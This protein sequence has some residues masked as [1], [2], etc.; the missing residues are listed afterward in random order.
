MAMQTF[1]EVAEYPG[2][3]QE[4]CLR[5]IL[6]RYPVTHEYRRNVGTFMGVKIDIVDA[7][8][9]SDR[10]IRALDNAPWLVPRADSVPPDHMSAATLFAG[11]HRYN[12]IYKGIF[13]YENIQ[14]IRDC[15]DE[16]THL[17]IQHGNADEHVA[18]RTTMHTVKL[19]EAKWPKMKVDLQ[20]QPGKA[21]AWEYSE[22]LSPEV[23]AQLEDC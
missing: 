23:R 19:L 20:I 6:L 5:K 7:R 16:R 15:P 18:V 10:A 4:F 3:P 12:Q 22:T 14:A 8:S 17:L 13:P 9:A 2:R 21:H 1:L 11:L